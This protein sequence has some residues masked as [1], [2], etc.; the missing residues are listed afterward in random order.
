MCGRFATGLIA[1]HLDT[2]AWL[3]IERD[4]PRPD[5][6]EDWVASGDETRAPLLPVIPA[7]DWPRPSWNVAPTQHAAIVVS[8]ETGVARRKV[9]SARW[10]LVPRWWRKSLAELKASTFNARSEEAAGKPMFR[11]ACAQTRCLVPAL[12]YYEWTGKARAKT[13][14]FVSPQSNRPGLCFAGLWAE[15]VVDGQTIR[16]FTILTTAANDATAHL[17]PRAPVVVAEDDWEAWLTGGAGAHL[18]RPLDATRTEVREVHRDVGNVRNDR[19]DLI[20]AVG[21]GL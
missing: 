5:W 4:A 1:G 18:M 2:A 12:G 9:L 10:G 6:T 20:E 21:L 11:D 16:S 14:W 3:D 8:D 7:G 19:P 13:P 17:H 15:A